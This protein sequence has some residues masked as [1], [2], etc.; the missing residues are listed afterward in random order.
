[1]RVRGSVGR[2]SGAPLRASLAM[3]DAVIAM[4]GRAQV[5][6]RSPIFGTALQPCGK[7][8]DQVAQDRRLAENPAVLSQQASVVP[9]AEL[10]R[11]A[12]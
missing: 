5:T 9:D 7:R 1:M 3:A 12:V 4:T 6:G 2:S 8:A 10:R 11:R